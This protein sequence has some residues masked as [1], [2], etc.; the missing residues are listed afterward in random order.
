MSE[1]AMLVMTGSGLSDDR[2]INTVLRI[3]MMS[4]GPLTGRTSL[5]MLPTSGTSSVNLVPESDLDILPPCW[6]RGPAFI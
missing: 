4:S 5:R 2:L 3:L 6:L 1:M